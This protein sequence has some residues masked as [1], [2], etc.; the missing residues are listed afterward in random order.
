MLAT[1]AAAEAQAGDGAG[2]SDKLTL[3]VPGE[4]AS[5]LGWLFL[6]PGD[7]IE[8][9]A[10]STLGF[11]QGYSDW[12]VYVGLWRW[13]VGGF[14]GTEVTDRGFTVYGWTDPPEPKERT[15][16]LRNS[17]TT[18]HMVLELS[19]GMERLTL[20][21]DAQTELSNFEIVH[22]DG[23]RSAAC[24]HPY[25]AGDRPERVCFSEP[26]IAVGD[27]GEVRSEPFDL[28]PNEWITM[29][30]LDER[31][32][33]V[34]DGEL[35]TFGTWGDWNIQGALVAP[36]AP[37][38]WSDPTSPDAPIDKDTENTLLVWSRRG[39]LDSRIQLKNTSNLST[40]Q[41]VFRISYAR[42]GDQNNPNRASS[43]MLYA[44]VDGQRFCLRPNESTPGWDRAPTCA[45]DGTSQMKAT[46]TNPSDSAE[47]YRIVVVDTV[48]LDHLL[49]AE[50]TTVPAGGA[51][52]LSLSGI[53]DGRWQLTVY[54]GTTALEPSKV[55]TFDQHYTCVE[56][57]DPDLQWDRAAVCT[58]GTAS[59]VGVEIRN[60]RSTS[61]SYQ[62]EVLDPSGQLLST[63]SAVQIAGKSS[64]RVEVSGLV[65]GSVMTRVLENGVPMGAPRLYGVGTCSSGSA[66]G[67][68][69]ILAGA[70]GSGEVSA[71][72]T[73]ELFN[74]Q[75]A[76]IRVESSSGAF[77]GGGSWSLPS[78]TTDTF[79]VSGI[80]F[81]S[82]V[83]TVLLDGKVVSR[84]ASVEVAKCP[85][86]PVTGLSMRYETGWSTF[87]NPHLLAKWS[88]DVPGQQEVRWFYDQ[89]GPEIVDANFDGAF[90]TETV[91]GSSSM[92]EPDEPGLTRNRWCVAVRSVGV[93]EV[94]AWAG[95]NCAFTLKCSTR[96]VSVMLGRGETPTEGDDTIL[97]T[98]FPDTIDALDGDDWVCPRNGDDD[99][100][101]GN[102]D[103]RVWSSHGNDIVYGGP[104][105]DRLYGGDGEDELHGGLG[106]DY[107]NGNSGDDHL[108]G[109]A[110][111]DTV[112]GY[113]GEDHLFGGD[114]NDYLG[115]H[116][117]DDVLHGG[118]GN[119]ILYGHGQAD[120]MYGD[121]GDDKLYGSWGADVLFGGAGADRIEAGNDND[122]LYG[123]PDDDDLYGQGHDDVLV[124]GDGQDYG[125][126]GSGSDRC[127]EIETLFRCPA[128]EDL[129]TCTT[130]AQG[131]IECAPDSFTATNECGSSTLIV[132]IEK[133][134]PTTGTTFTIRINSFPTTVVDTSID[135]LVGESNGIQVDV[136][137][138][139]YA[140]VVT[141]ENGSQLD[142]PPLVSV[143]T[144]EC[145]VPPWLSDTAEPVLPPWPNL[146]EQREQLYLRDHER[147]FIDK[148]T[149]EYFIE[150][151]N[152]PDGPKYVAESLWLTELYIF[153]PI[154]RCPLA[155]ANCDDVTERVLGMEFV[156]AIEYVQLPT[157]RW[158]IEW[159]NDTIS[160]GD[161]AKVAQIKFIFGERLNAGFSDDI[162]H[163]Y[164]ANEYWDTWTP[165]VPRSLLSDIHL[166]LDILGM[167]P[168]GGEIADSINAV[169]YVAE[170]DIANAMI[171]GAALVPFGGQ[172]A[173]GARMAERA[174]GV[175]D[176]SLSAADGTLAHVIRRADG[177]RIV[178]VE[179]LD[180]TT[181]FVAKNGVN[182]IDDIAQMDTVLL[183][184][185]DQ[186]VLH[187][188]TPGPVISTVAVRGPDGIYN[189]LLAEP[190]QN[191]L[192]SGGRTIVDGVENPGLRD[193]VTGQNPM[194]V[195]TDEFMNISDV[196]TYLNR[197][198]DVY[199]AA[200]PSG[201]G[202][203][204]DM[205][206]ALESYLGNGQNIRVYDAGHAGGRFPGTHAEIVAVNEALHEGRDLADIAVS[207][208]WTDAVAN[209][210]TR[211]PGTPAFT[212]PNCLGILN[213][214][215]ATV[216][217]NFPGP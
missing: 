172:A 189:D 106:N 216:L 10:T 132:L 107:V 118:P 35:Q 15:V 115:G 42:T 2:C 171:S 201:R 192:D 3:K 153:F 84:D 147:L 207:S 51:A 144:V 142:G 109:D 148:E 55:F 9:T 8:M 74:P 188:D 199:A 73:N 26:R 163:D 16:T 53:P 87:D 6:E 196:P 180:G 34:I 105:E 121:D 59:A 100:V 205:R 40:V 77:I 217:T 93:G 72:V 101:G 1:P 200:S 124:G 46:I 95:P 138:G 88:D 4:T 123:G 32:L 63:S 66:G 133:N 195:Q 185:L 190:T 165:F 28:A 21:Q 126:G 89:T 54:Q 82:F 160:F 150:V 36:G 139:T 173:T 170:G 169:I 166:A 19:Y 214:T 52:E 110:D 98:V 20:E 161:D 92:L 212:C 80:P 113:A 151:T 162:V 193:L 64:G 134:D 128:A 215:P 210:A 159:P 158:R 50:P 67:S 14:P 181:T 131:A 176:E 177:S 18:A 186:L 204:P 31:V 146:S 197:V 86:E 39:Y 5:E 182:V 202:L 125:N 30:M 145:H 62:I 94:S 91:A 61:A 130:N 156:T 194:V 184:H 11:R 175:L 104:G 119:D 99:V 70:C 44:L 103:D 43:S 47:T 17:N 203:H 137:N 38:N 114:G 33:N 187:L 208:M 57:R 122:V 22:A 29:K 178:A 71:E 56:E 129:R 155:L 102:G 168:V 167:V 117:A 174:R 164:V 69:S 191:L 48:S 75:N 37:V 81:G 198:D 85:V 206:T 108:H 83:V 24:V 41:V 27:P 143:Q 136:P 65:N 90:A 49:D 68:A 25:D 96:L 7:S 45:A 78:Q 209:S 140:V 111:D 112:L 149:G 116:S 152:G 58:G 157:G 60:N 120:T 23:S 76:T 12:N 97:G 13:D 183:R 135:V 141:D 127:D 79:T 213:A 154:A 179:L 211:V